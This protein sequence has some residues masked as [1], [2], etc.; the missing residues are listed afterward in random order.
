MRSDEISIAVNGV[1]EIG[2]CPSFIDQPQDFTEYEVKQNLQLRQLLGD[3]YSDFL[4]STYHSPIPSE[5]N[6]KIYLQYIS[7]S[8]ALDELKHLFEDPEDVVTSSEDQGVLLGQSDG[9]EYIAVGHVGNISEDLGQ[10]TVDNVEAAED[11][12]DYNSSNGE[13]IGVISGYESEPIVII[14]CSNEDVRDYKWLPNMLDEHGVLQCS[15]SGNNMNATTPVEDYYSD[16][17]ALKMIY[18]EK[19]N[20]YGQT[21]CRYWFDR[22]K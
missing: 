14:P 19:T 1:E 20:I 18:Q 12:P 22:G 3:E 4:M 21:Y 13:V 17:M 11:S 6:F 15:E 8:S 10:N 5:W 16:T 9:E 7:N 2:E